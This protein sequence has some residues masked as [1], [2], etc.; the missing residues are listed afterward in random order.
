MLASVVVGDLELSLRHGLG[1]G[2]GERNVNEGGEGSLDEGGDGVLA[3]GGGGSNGGGGASGGGRGSGGGRVNRK[4]SGG[5]DGVN[6]DGG[7]S[8]GVNDGGRSD[9]GDDGGSGGGNVLDPG[10]GVGGADDDFK[11]GA[12]L[13]LIVGIGEVDLA[14]PESTLD[15]DDGLGVG[16]LVETGLDGWGTLEVDVERLAAV[17]F[18]TLVS[19]GAG[20]VL[21]ERLDGQVVGGAMKDVSLGM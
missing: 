2:D 5:G 14:A 1:L 19:A 18:V 17:D 7:G 16:A 6:D 21:V 20:V 4:D 3:G 10:V 11:I 13:T 9:G 8:D 12:E 15:A